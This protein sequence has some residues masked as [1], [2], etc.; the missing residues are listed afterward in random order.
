MDNDGLARLPKHTRID[1]LVVG[2]RGGDA[3]QRTASHD[4]KAA[5]DRLDCRHL[6]LVCAD[7][8]VEG[9]HVRSFEMVGAATAG[10]QRRAT[11]T[12]FPRLAGGDRAFDQF[13]RGRPVEAHAALGSVHGFRDAEA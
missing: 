1:A 13:K 6:V 3:R 5:A 12:R 7:D 4:Y 8:V 9:A 10:D 2:G 11:F